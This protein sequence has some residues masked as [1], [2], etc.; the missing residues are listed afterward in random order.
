MSYLQQRKENERNTALA[1]FMAKQWEQQNSVPDAIQPNAQPAGLS[2]QID[3]L[4]SK[5]KQDPFDSIGQFTFTPN[6]RDSQGYQSMNPYANLGPLIKKGIPVNT[7]LSLAQH[8]DQERKTKADK[9]ITQEKIKNAV[10]RLGQAKTPQEAAGIAME[11]GIDPK[12]ASMMVPERSKYSMVNTQNGTLLLVDQN[13]NVRNVGNFAKPEK[14][15]SPFKS[16][17][18]MI[19][20]SRS[21]QVVYTKPTT[22]KSAA[23]QTSE[24]KALAVA[25]NQWMKNNAMKIMSG[26]ITEENSPYWGRMVAHLEGGQASGQQ[27]QQVDNSL[28]AQYIR[29]AKAEGKT[30][31]EI[32]NNLHSKGITEYDSYV[33]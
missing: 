29:Q 2:A 5:Q 1:D 16:G 25:H 12:W 8:S 31:D 24:F 13:G 17:N 14:P 32:I 30:K 3:D 21:G 6:Q 9:I 26:E 18:G 27:T 23:Q 4:F 10:L 22:D 28:P 19:F 15:E 20:D 33:W 11:S 7:L